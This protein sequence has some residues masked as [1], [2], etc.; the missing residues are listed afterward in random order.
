MTIRVGIIGTGVMGADHA[1]L[2]TGAVSGATVSAVFDVDRERAATVADAS[3][4]ARVLADPIEL[5]GDGAVDAVLV[6]SSDPTHEE[7]VLASIAAGKPVLCEKPLAP[8]V[9]GCARILDAETAFGSR[10]VTVGFMR[11]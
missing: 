7:F 1:R 2:L 9:E 8:T 10:L 6:A 3:A 11:R 4:R 5:I